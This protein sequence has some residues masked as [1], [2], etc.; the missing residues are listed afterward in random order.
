MNFWYHFANNI[1]G[2]MIGLGVAS[3]FGGVVS[4]AGHVE[5][6][7]KAMKWF[8]VALLTLSLASFV[9]S[10]AL[11]AYVEANTP[12]PKSFFALPQLAECP[13]K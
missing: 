8:A 4:I 9:T 11:Y 6:F 2:L 7:G 1:K 5:G 10:A 3:C 13:G 12:M